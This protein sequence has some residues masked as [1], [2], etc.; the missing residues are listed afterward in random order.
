MQRVAL[1]IR[2]KPEKLN[3]YRKLHDPIWPELVA[4]LKAAGLRNYSLWLQPDGTEFGYVECDD[5]QASCDYLATSE[6]HTRWQEMMQDYLASPME[7]AAG[8]QPVE[9]L[10]RVFLM[11]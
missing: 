5:W 11:E 4:E 3:E 2:V 10:E 9:M 6:I 7:A 1:I 8:G